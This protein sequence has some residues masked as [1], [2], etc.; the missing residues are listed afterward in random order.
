MK[1][2]QNGF[3]L[4]E[5]LVAL[6]IVAVVLASASRAIGLIIS[7]VHDSFVREVATWVAENEYN[8]YLLNNQYPDLG[9]VKKKLSSAGVDF[10]VTETVLQTPNPYFRRIEITISE[11]STP[12]HMIYK[13]VNFI[14]QY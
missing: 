8:Q 10:N 9:I 4:I 3:T 11:K 2:Q 13:T 12:D 14:A 7:D 5:C 1:K 6:F